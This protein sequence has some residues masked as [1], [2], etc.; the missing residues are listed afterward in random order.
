MSRYSH[1][2]WDWNGTLIDDAW[3]G[4]AVMNEMLEKK[5]LPAITVDHYRRVFGFPVRDYYRQLGFAIDEDP[6]WEEVAND[7]I[8]GYHRRMH[9]V[10]LFADVEPTLAAF[11]ERGL[12]QV[13]LS[14]MEQATLS[15]HVAALGIDRYFVHIQGI[16]NHYAD[17]KGH[18]ARAM[19]ERLGVA[20]ERILFVG[21]TLHDIEAAR[22]L[23][24][25]CC[26]CSRGHQSKERLL[27]AGVP[28]VDSFGELITVL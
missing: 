16:D 9:E 14:A 26:L 7:F 18:M 3:L 23:G 27:A 24:C 11:R 12:T 5:G 10:K 22:R 19:G 17:G 6:V 8:G 1:I 13:I 25:D 2:I 15:R 20:P 4:V 28:V 21:D